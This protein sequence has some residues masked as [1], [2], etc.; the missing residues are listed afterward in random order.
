MAWLPGRT[1]ANCAFKPLPPRGDTP[2]QPPSNSPV[3][4][5]TPV[6]PAEPWV[7]SAR[8]ALVAAHRAPRGK[9][10][11]GSCLGSP[12]FEGRANRW[13]SDTF[14]IQMTHSADFQRNRGLTRAT[15]GFR[16]RHLAPPPD[17]RRRPPPAR[18]RRHQVPLGGSAGP[19]ALGRAPSARERVSDVAARR[20]HTGLFPRLR[21]DQQNGLVSAETRNSKPHWRH[22]RLSRGSTGGST[23]CATPACPARLTHGFKPKPHA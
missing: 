5:T 1:P 2:H 8:R 3:V 12:P 9:G 4:H 16:R 23:R 21:R 13:L 22:N 19:A 14:L 20:T 18:A 10:R 7:P 11:G 15:L 17:E 6:A